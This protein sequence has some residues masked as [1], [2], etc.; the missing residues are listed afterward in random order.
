VE[1]VLAQELLLQPRPVA[2]EVMLVAP[3]ETMIT[4]PQQERAR[5]KR[6]Q[7]VDLPEFAPADLAVPQAVPMG[8][9]VALLGVVVVVVEHP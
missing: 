1:V 5:A 9:Q 8:K 4:T 2:A 3:V 6:V 7:P